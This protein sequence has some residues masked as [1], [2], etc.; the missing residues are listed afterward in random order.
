MGYIL[1]YLIN[2]NRSA[3]TL[4]PTHNELLPLCV[5]SRVAHTQKTTQT[6]AKITTT[7]TTKVKVNILLHLA[8]FVFCICLSWRRKEWVKEKESCEKKRSRKKVAL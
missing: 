7:T 6:T 2:F 5:G 8:L 1:I 4:L 3:A